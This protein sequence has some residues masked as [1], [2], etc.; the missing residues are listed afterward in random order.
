[1]QCIAVPGLV[2]AAGRK[3]AVGADTPEVEGVRAL[4]LRAERLLL[5][6]TLQKWR[7]HA[8]VLRAE[9]LLLALAILMDECGVRAAK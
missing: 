2:G 9:R 5:A 3:A 4:V 1:M 8:L 6:P 7:V